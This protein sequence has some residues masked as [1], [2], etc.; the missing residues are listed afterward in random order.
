M[1][2][3]VSGRTDIVAFYSEWFKNRIKAGFFDVRNPINP[4]LVSRIFFEDVDLI[5]FC[6]KNPKPIISFLNDINK[7]II[8]NVTL[9]PYHKDIEPNVKD[10]NEI[11][12]DIIEISKKIGIDNV[13]L[14]YDP[15]IINDRYGINYH[16]NAF[17]R[18]CS[19]LNGYV[20]NII[21]SFVD[22]YKNLRKHKNEIKYKEISINDMKEI[23]S[24]LSSIANNYNIK[25]RG[26]AEI[27]LSEY[28]ILNESCFSQKLAFEKTGKVYKIGSW[29]GNELCK[30]VTMADIG[31]YNSCKHLCKY[32][33][34]N[35]NEDLINENYLNHNPNSS[36]LIGELLEDDIIKIRKK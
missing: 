15:I 22:D 1:I 5:V 23:A 24:S 29:R 16:K 20:K 30:C 34:A 27:D 21:I 14:R 9:T 2:L 31:A 13:F 32:C 19:L 18:L 11:I 3:N 17:N 28:G 7:P 25:V 10:K 33:Y 26:C 6:T 36:L 12:N 8:F 4:K 35:F